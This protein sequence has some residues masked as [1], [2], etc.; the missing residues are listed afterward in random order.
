MIRCERRAKSPAATTRCAATSSRRPRCW[1][2]SNSAASSRAT[3]CSASAAWV[4]RPARAVLARDIRTSHPWGVFAGTL[5]HESIVKTPW[6][7]DGPADGALPRGAAIGRIHRPPA[8]PPRTGMRERRHPRPDYA[9]PLAPSS[10][11]FG[12]VEGWRGETC[13]V[14]LTDTQGRIAAC[15]H[16]GPQPAQLAGAGAGRARRRHL[17]LPDLQQEFQPLLLRPRFVN[18]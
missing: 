16:Q 15:P 3:R 18:D 12:L 4:R 14:L 5:R 13:H 9:A 10:L 7:R 1:P 17:G 2:A 8:R 11:A 6:R